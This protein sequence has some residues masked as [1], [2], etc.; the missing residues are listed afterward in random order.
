MIP[1]HWQRSLLCLVLLFCCTAP[2]TL[3]AVTKRESLRV[4]NRTSLQPGQALL[5]EFDF[6]IKNFNMDHQGELHTLTIRI[7]MQYVR[8]IQNSAYPDFRLIARDVETYL[9]KYPNKTDYWEI[10]NK[11][12]TELILHRYLPISRVRSE[13][14]I[15]ASPLVPYDRVSTATRVRTKKD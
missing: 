5:E 7:S 6:Y 3:V 13:V 8:G 12:L 2:D 4:A 11:K 15:S 1:I 14:E 10:V 9:S